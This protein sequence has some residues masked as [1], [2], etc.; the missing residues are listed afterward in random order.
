VEHKAGHLDHGTE[1]PTL[2]VSFVIIVQ[3]SANQKIGD[4]DPR[5]DKERCYKI[6]EKAN[7]IG[8]GALEAFMALKARINQK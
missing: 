5:C 6:S 3:Q 7:A 2:E 8:K 1:Y 4:V